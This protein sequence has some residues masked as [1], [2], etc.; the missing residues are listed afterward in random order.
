MKNLKKFVALLLAGVMAMVMLTACSGGGGG[1]S[2]EKDAEAEVLKNLS[3]RTEA[4]SLVKDGELKNDRDVYRFAKEA[5]DADIRA[6]YGSAYFKG[7]IHHD[8]IDPAKKYVT[9]VVTMDYRFGTILTNVMSE[10][11]KA[12]GKV[13]GNANVKLDSKWAGVGVVVE[14]DAKGTYMAVGIRVLNLAYPKT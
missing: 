6:S 12:F 1:G 10:L 3:S 14:S 9:L 7:D 5:L 11:S 13:G 2:V 8:G 4:A